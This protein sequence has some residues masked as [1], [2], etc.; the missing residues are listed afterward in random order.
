MANKNLISDTDY[1]DGRDKRFASSVCI[2]KVSKMEVSEKGAN[3]RALLADR[4]DHK[5]NPLITRPVPVLQICAGGKKSFAMPRVGQ[6]V[7]LTK[8]PNS[9]SCY[10]AMGFFYTSKDP[11][12][13]TDPKL[14]YVEWEGGHTQT[15]DANTDDNGNPKNDVFLTQ[16]FKGG[17]KGTYKKDVNLNTTDSAKFNIVADGDV[18]INSANGNIDVQSPNGTITIE[19]KNITL[20]GTVTIE[21]DIKHTGN[22]QTSGIH[23]AADGPHAS[24]GLA[25]GELETR[26]ATLEARLAALEARANG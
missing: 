16:D 18:K 7:F 15:H 22:M 23:T 1:T 19:Q 12:P 20:K 11:P 13:V 25:Q 5:G 6:N 17:W 2:G 24:C 3:I 4:L 21:G 8:L 14:D 10:A 26:I 9:T